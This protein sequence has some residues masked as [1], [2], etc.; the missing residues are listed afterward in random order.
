MPGGQNG[1]N[2]W[3]ERREEALYPG[4]PC[5]TGFTCIKVSYDSWCYTSC[6]LHTIGHVSFVVVQ[7]TEHSLWSGG[8]E[9]L[10]N[11]TT[12]A[13][14]NT[15]P[16]REAMSTIFVIFG[17]TRSQGKHLTTR[18]LGWSKSRLENPNTNPKATTELIMLF[19]TVISACFCLIFRIQDPL[20]MNLV[21]DP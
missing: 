14:L 18:P 15:V 19:Q 6:W 21:P 13:T 3:G 4:S 8:Q 10:V 11:L 9:S 7:N 16:R 12:M 5:P 20:A 2:T 17:M 1:R